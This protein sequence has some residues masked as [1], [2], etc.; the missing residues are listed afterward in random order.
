MRKTQRIVIA[1]SGDTG[2]HLAKMLSF[3][4]QD[5]TLMSSDRRYLESLD[6]SYN[7]MVSAG[8]PTSPADLKASGV[9]KA[10]LF[11]AVTPHETVNMVAASLA[12]SLGA[13]KCVARVSK[14]EYLDPVFDG[15]FAGTGIDTRVYPE[16]LVVADIIKFIKRNWVTGWFEFCSGQLVLAGV[17]INPGAP[18]AGKRLKELPELRL[19]VHVSA[20]RRNRHIIIPGGDDY[21]L[22]GDVAFFTFIP[23]NEDMVTR[24]TGQQTRRVRNI[25]ISGTGPVTR[26]L[27]ARLGSDYR[28]TVIDAN[29]ERCR[30]F[31]DRFPNVAVL[32]A[33]PKDMETLQSE[34]M[35]GMDMFLGLDSDS[36]ANMV[37]CMMAREMGVPRTVAEIED[38]EY[39]GV[40]E[41]L[42]I[43]KAVNK[44]LIT[45]ATI[46]RQ[47]MGKSLRVDSIISL[48]DAEVAEIEI[49]DKLG[50]LN[51][52]VRDLRL[53]KGLTLGG[54][55]RDGRGILV[56]GDTCILPGDKLMVM[57]M[58]GALENVL[59]IFR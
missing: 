7:M 51:L 10:D 50:I 54:I 12:H 58:P 56:D 43:D 34:G 8:D 42:M 36:D 32:N 37:S 26:M 28:L 48:P 22:A 49:I 35:E 16:A 57:F 17:K 46:L 3:E 5:V 55:A 20:I 25:M 53:P 52:P 45:S 38:I 15:Y 4:N 1:G 59:R 39:I 31:A 9:E 19:N 6:S 30:R 2:T 27:A 13:G 24:I 11:V 23:D 47:I 29:A 33:S 44:K 18:I 40:A 41:E 21:M 14:E